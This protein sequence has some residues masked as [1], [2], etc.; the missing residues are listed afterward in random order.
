MFWASIEFLLFVKFFFTKMIKIL[1]LQESKIILFIIY[2]YFNES[3]KSKTIFL[4]KLSKTHSSTLIMV[5]MVY[6]I[7]LHMSRLTVH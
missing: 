4:L 6:R 3:A 7:F 5:L 1:N 2:F